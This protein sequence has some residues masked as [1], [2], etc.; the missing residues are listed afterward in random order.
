[1]GLILVMAL[2]VL[3]AAAASLHVTSVT[4]MMLLAV[5]FSA[6]VTTAGLAAS[7]AADLPAG[8]TMV[9]AAGVLY[10]A[11][12]ALRKSRGLTP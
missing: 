3:P 6:L 12:L 1:V 7:F 4:R 2:L 5:A 9:V 11:A 8:A 10:A